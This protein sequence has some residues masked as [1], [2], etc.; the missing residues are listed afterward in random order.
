MAVFEKVSRKQFE[1]LREKQ[2]VSYLIAVI[3]FRIKLR[4][5][6]NKDII[7]PSIKN[8][9]KD[10]IL[11]ESS[12]SQRKTRSS[13]SPPVGGWSRPQP[14]N[15]HRDGKYDQVGC[16]ICWCL[17]VL[18]FYCEDGKYGQVEMDRNHP[19]KTFDNVEN[20]RVWANM[21]KF[22]KMTIPIHMTTEKR[23]KNVCC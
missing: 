9:T 20:G 14:W 13:P 7:V 21:T 16:W 11:V 18:L 8:S 10:K 3:W 2:Q 17:F 22:L 15:S 23:R 5:K 4:S 1:S 19:A 12:K 6:D